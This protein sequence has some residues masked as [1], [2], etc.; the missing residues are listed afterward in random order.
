MACSHLESKYYRLFLLAPMN[1]AH[2]T[3]VASR[4]FCIDTAVKGAI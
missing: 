4:L 2:G 3:N 1:A